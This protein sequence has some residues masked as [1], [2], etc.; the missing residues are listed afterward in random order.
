MNADL[1]F[2]VPAQPSPRLAWM[3]RHNVEVVAVAELEKIDPDAVDAARNENLFPDAAPDV[4]FLALRSSNKRTL[5][6][7]FAD[8]VP[9][10]DGAFRDWCFDVDCATDNAGNGPTE[11]EACY[12]FSRKNNLPLWIVNGIGGAK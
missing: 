1:L 9:M 4:V 6:L 5:E 11:A 8:G 7:C 2:D 10:R 3:A 12:D